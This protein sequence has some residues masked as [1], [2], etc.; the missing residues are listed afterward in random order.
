M[1]VVCRPLVGLNYRDASVAEDLA[2][3]IHKLL[4]ANVRK[5]EMIDQRKVAEWVDEHSWEEYNEV[6]KALDADYVVGVDLESFSI[7]QGQTVFQGKADVVL[8]V[9]DGKQD[10]PV[11]ERRL[12]EI[13]YP[14]HNPRSTYDERESEFRCEYIGVLADHIARHF[15]PHDPYADF[16]QH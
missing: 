7:F 16:A 5:V 4:A 8:K 11:F 13:V 9:F 15:Y 3:E 10:D 6:G 1:A 14:P 12:P 2:R